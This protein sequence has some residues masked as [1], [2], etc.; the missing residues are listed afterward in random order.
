MDSFS[1]FWANSDSKKDKVL[2]LSLIRFPDK[3]DPHIKLYRIEIFSWY[4][5]S[6]IL[7]VQHDQ[8]GFDLEFDV[9]KFK[10]M[11]DVVNAIKEHQLRKMA[12]KINDLIPLTFDILQR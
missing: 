2:E 6:R 12:E 7:A 1:H 4:N 11:D 10:A 5:S 9:M 3:E 8:A